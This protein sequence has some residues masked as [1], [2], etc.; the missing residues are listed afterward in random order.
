[1]EGTC[2]TGRYG[3]RNTNDCIIGINVVTKEFIQ[4][5]QID[6]KFYPTILE[7]KL[8]D[9]KLF[10]FCPRCGHR[11]GG[12]CTKPVIS[13]C[14]HKNTEVVNW[15]DGGA[16]EHCLCCGMSRHMWEQGETEWMYVDIDEAKANLEKLIEKIKKGEKVETI[17]STVSLPWL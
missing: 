10:T 6:Y 2:F 12:L 4:K 17:Y 5:K 1:M 15:P 9:V 7:K 13:G 14:R 3:N 11:I 16:V 8:K